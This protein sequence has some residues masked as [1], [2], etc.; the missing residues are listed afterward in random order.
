VNLG[1]AATAAAIPTVKALT[2]WSP[3]A[4]G[5][6]SLLASVL[7]GIALAIVKSGPGW[8]KASSDSKRATAEL[9]AEVRAEQRVENATTAARLTALE[10][11]MERTGGALVFCINALTTAID[12]LES[13]DKRVRDL[14]A[15]RARE[16]IAFA[17]STLG[18]EDPFSKALAR[19]AAVAPVDKKEGE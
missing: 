11:R 13:D 18:A 3:A 9:A 16:S 6:W 1:S 10:G 14:A 15:S 12:G 5:I 4:V 17:A 2:G 7:G 19:L 8:I